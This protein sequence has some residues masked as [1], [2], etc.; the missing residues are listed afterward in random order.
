L[1]ADL[2]R[3]GIGWRHVWLR[4]PFFVS[5]PLLAYARWRGYSWHE[6]RGAARHGYWSFS[7]S[8]LLRALLPWTLLIDAAL[9][10]L[11]RIYLPLWLG[12]VVVCERFVLDVLVDLAVAF[13]EPDLYARLPGRLYLHLIPRRSAVVCLD[14]DVPTTRARRPDL[15]WDR[16]L[17]ARVAAFRRLAA[18]CGV[19]AVSTVAPVERVHAEIQHLVHAPAVAGP[20]GYARLRSPLLR[21]LASSPLLALAAHWMLQSLLYMDRTERCAKL[22]LELALALL[23]RLLLGGALPGAAAWAVAL[24]AAHTANFFLNAHLWGVMKHYGLARHTW[25][26]YAR[27]VDGFT[28]RAR[29]EPAI[30]SLWICGSLSHDAWSPASDLDVRLLRRPGVGNGARACWFLLRERTRALWCRFPLDAYVVDSRSGLLAR[31]ISATDRPVDHASWSDAVS[32]SEAIPKNNT[33][34]CGNLRT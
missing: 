17:P 26:A 5:V 19:P 33:E 1:T 34:I 3:R 2:A 31:G 18:A 16:C 28:A 20:A 10:A 29:R 6:A 12:H 30:D 32:E 21:H 11:C 15:G 8:R 23:A 4:Y 13:D 9:A 25:E 22:A 14:L 24:V 27:Y 7:G